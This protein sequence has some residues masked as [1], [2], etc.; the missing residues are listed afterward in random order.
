VFAGSNLLVIQ[1]CLKNDTKYLYFL[2]TPCV[3]RYTCS[4]YIYCSSTNKETYCW[5]HVQTYNDNF[6][7][8]VSHTLTSSWIDDDGGTVDCINRSI[9]VCISMVS[10]HSTRQDYAVTSI[11]AD[12]NFYTRHKSHD[13]PDPSRNLYAIININ[14]YLLIKMRYIAKFW[15]RM[16]RCAVEKKRVHRL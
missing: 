1:F 3:H 6:I 5:F 9:S 4:I 13:D 12:R 10:S 2:L 14:A 16:R 8:F 7:L 11:V 15:R